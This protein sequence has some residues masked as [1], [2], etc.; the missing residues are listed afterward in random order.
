VSRLQ[1]A[2]DCFQAWASHS[3]QIGN[4]AFPPSPAICRA[5]DIGCRPSR[6]LAGGLGAGRV[7]WT[8]GIRVGASTRATLMSLQGQHRGAPGRI[9]TE[10]SSELAPLH[11]QLP[12]VGVAHYRRRRVLRSEAFNPSFDIPL[13]WGSSPSTTWV[14]SGR[15]TKASSNLGRLLQPLGGLAKREA[16]RDHLP[17]AVGDDLWLEAHLGSPLW[18]GTLE[19]LGPSYLLIGR[20]KALGYC[21]YLGDEPG[22]R[23]NR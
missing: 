1:A 14:S 15:P 23:A 12:A 17:E 16:F 18:S 21:C 9:G 10:R 11:I 2:N 19:C 6:H 13:A 20:A 4:V 7:R 5:G 3:G 22:H 8:A